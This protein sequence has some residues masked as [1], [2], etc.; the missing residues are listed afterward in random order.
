M[1]AEHLK[2][3]K[4]VNPAST[5]SFGEGGGSPGFE[6]TCVEREHFSPS[7]PSKGAH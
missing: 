7:H 3:G 1:A 6:V 4:T 5:G 2:P